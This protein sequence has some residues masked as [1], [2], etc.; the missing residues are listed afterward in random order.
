MSFW[1][2]RRVLMIGRV[3]FLG[4]FVMEKPRERGCQQIFVPRIRDD[5]LR[6]AEAIRKLLK[7]AN[8]DPV[9]DLAARVGAIRAT[10]A[11]PAAFFYDNLMMAVHL[12]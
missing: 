12:L 1:G 7:T 3:G 11:H 2:R 6:Q 9:I 8:P 10:R 5:D 4:S